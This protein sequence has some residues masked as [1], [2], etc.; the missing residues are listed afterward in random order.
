MLVSRDCFKGG[1]KQ[2]PQG[3]DFRV[4]TETVSETVHYLFK[5][6]LGL[7]FL[8][9]SHEVF[10][11]A[12]FSSLWAH[13]AE[14]VFRHKRAVKPQ[15]SHSPARY[16]RD[17]DE[18]VAVAQGSGVGDEGVVHGGADAV[19]GEGEVVPRAQLVVEGGGS[20]GGGRELFFGEAAL[21]AEDGE[22]LDR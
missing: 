10:V 18:A 15:R 9:G 12:S 22:I 16:R 5:A 17:E 1:P 14:H 11:G 3:V 2:I 8:R 4:I 6:R 21:F 19:G 20:G 13:H 7:R